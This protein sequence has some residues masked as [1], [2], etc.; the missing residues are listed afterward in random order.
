MSNQAPAPKGDDSSQQPVPKRVPEGL[1]GNAGARLSGAG[2]QRSGGRWPLFA[3]GLL[4]ITL[5]VGGILWAMGIARA[6]GG[7]R[8]RRMRPAPRPRLASFPLPPVSKSPFRNT[9]QEATYVGSDSCTGCHKRLTASFRSTGMGSSMAP[10]D[11][12]REPADAAFDHASSKSRFQIQRKDGQLWHRELLLTADPGEVVLEEYPVKFV[13]G[14]GRFARTYLAEAEGFLVESPVTWYTSR[15]AWDLSPGYDRPDHIGFQRVIGENCLTCHAGRAEAIEKTQHRMLITE[16]AISCERCH[17]PGSLH[18]EL[19]S[20]PKAETSPPA[21]EID[22]TIINPMHLPRELAEAVCQQCHVLGAGVVLNRG[23][24]LA[25]FRPGLP[26]EEFRLDF[27]P[28][29]DNIPLKVVGHVEQ[30]HLSRCYTQSKTLTCTTCHDPHAF[31]RPEERV[32]YY[33]DI[34]LKCHQAQQCTVAKEQLLHKS[35]DNDCTKCHMPYAATNVP[36]VAFAHHRIAV[37]ERPFSAPSRPIP[38][39]GPGT[40]LVPFRD[41]VALGEMDRKRA[42]GLAFLALA[43]KN[44]SGRAAE[45]QNQAFKLLTAVHGA[46]L[47]DPVLLA[48]LSR[49]RFEQGQ[50]GAALLAGSALDFPDIAGTE[51][52]TALFVIAADFLERKQYK[53]ALAGFRELVT[54]RRDAVDWF[55][56]AQCQSGLSN[57]ASMVQALE[58]ALR[59]NPRLQDVRRSLAEHYRCRGDEYAPLGTSSGSSSAPPMPI[60]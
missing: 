43:D 18:A 22:F 3:V 28:E 20:N 60:K 44:H 57:S 46:G 12:A 5:T 47:R 21:Q 58:M 26:L 53:D 15:K 31:P 7:P 49:L 33:R 4:A 36:H 10:V 29:A 41:Y 34:C 8:L 14:S 23:K 48:H 59:I 19:H 9:T 42:L 16:A 38:A 50:F 39:E 13:V 56:L 40:V 30:L 17:G 35:P 25:D 11:P 24:R 6:A 54:L 32:A 1:F 27:E 51:R 52:V 37:H 45:F 2:A 55:M